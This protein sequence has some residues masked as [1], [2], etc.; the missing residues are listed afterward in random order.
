[1]IELNGL[2]R[3]WDKEPIH[4]YTPY[5]VSHNDVI[6]SPYSDLNGLARS[7][8]YERPSHYKP[9]DHRSILSRHDALIASL[10]QQ[11][12]MLTTVLANMTAITDDEIYQIT[13]V[14]IDG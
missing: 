14:E 13:G 1:M 5:S 2:M 9:Y 10:Q 6:Y 8:D 3:S 11:I 4:E 7:W 12:T